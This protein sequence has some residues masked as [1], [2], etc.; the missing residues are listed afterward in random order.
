VAPYNW[1]SVLAMLRELRPEYK[2]PA[3]IPDP[4]HDLSTITEEKAKAE[5][6][7]VRMGRPGFSELREALEE[8]LSSLGY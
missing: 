5:K 4:G 2:F 6:L 1:N 7:L 3:D 8:N